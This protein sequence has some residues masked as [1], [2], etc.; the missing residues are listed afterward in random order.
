[1]NLKR[2]IEIAVQAHKGQV[3][4]AGQP[5][6]LHPLR[7]MMNVHSDNAKI[8]AVLHDVIEDSNLTLAD[9]IIEEFSLDIVDAL[10]LLTK[11]RYD[12][13]FD[14]IHNIKDSKNNLA[15]LVKLADLEDNMD[16][17]RLKETTEQDE[18]RYKKYL[19]AKCIL[20]DCKMN[21]CES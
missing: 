21:V 2:A 14:Y 9:L 8:V 18:K 6:I 7:V 12:K 10:R 15:I 17:S 19:D 20:M 4:K 3:D 1:M 16:M 11:R 5:Y 13:Y